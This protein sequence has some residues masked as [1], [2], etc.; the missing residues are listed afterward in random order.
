LFHELDAA[1]MQLALSERLRAIGEVATFIAH[2]VKNP[3]G[4]IQILVGALQERW[5]EPELRAKVFEVVPREVDRLNRAVSQILDYA[6][7]T[8][9]I[10]VPVSLVSLAESALEALGPQIERQ[11][12]RVHTDFGLDVPVVLADGERVREVLVNLVK[13]SLEAMGE[14]P[15]KELRVTV[16]RQDE[17]H[18]EIALEDSGA[19]IPDDELPHV[20]EPFRTSKK[21]GT[22][23]GLALC[24]KVVREHGGQITAENIPHGGARFRLSLPVSGA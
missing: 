21:T 5:A 14:A 12:V 1:R 15:R 13:N 23:V 4:S 8:P 2:E 11:Q 3:L 24:Q 16:R 18:V 10:K 19:G 6:R 22:G 20:F 7:P 17:A 9:L